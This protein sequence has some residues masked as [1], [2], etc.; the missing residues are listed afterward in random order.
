MWNAY[1]PLCI[2]MSAPHLKGNCKGGG[3][4]VASIINFP[5][6]AWTCMDFRVRRLVIYPKT[7]YLVRIILNIPALF[8]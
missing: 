6:A 8:L 2:I 7:R 5:P 1:I 4:N 3:A